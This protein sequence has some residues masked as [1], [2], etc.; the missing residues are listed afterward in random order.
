M[1]QADAAHGRGFPARAVLPGLGLDAQAGAVVG[2]GQRLADFVEIFFG[3]G[4]LAVA[5]EGEQDA[6]G[7]GVVFRPGHVVGQHLCGT[8][9]FAEAFDD[10]MPV[11]GVQF[12][13]GGEVVRVFA[14]VFAFFISGFSCFHAFV[15]RQGREDVVAVVSVFVGG[16]DVVEGRAFF[17][18]PGYGTGGQGVFRRPVVF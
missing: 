16:R 7:G 11:G 3:G 17:Q 2:I 14:L 5:V 8:Q 4:G 18:L 12:G 1:L 13:Q 6:V 10:G 15:L 9:P